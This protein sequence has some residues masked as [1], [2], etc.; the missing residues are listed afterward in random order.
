MMSGLAPE[1]S[2]FVRVVERGSFAAVA[3]EKGY[4]AS[5]V[6]RM[7]S[8]LEHSLGTKLLF[9][10]TRQLSLTPE[11][12][13]FLPHAQRVLE[14]IELAGAEISYS[15]GSPQGKIRINCGTAFANH[16]LAPML[17]E[18]TKRYPNIFLDIAV[19]DQRVDPVFSQADV[20]IRVGDLADSGLISIPLGK[21]A[22][23]I[24]ASPNYIAKHGTPCE[25]SDL[26]DHNCL[27]LSGF[28]GQSS[29]P[30]VKNGRHIKVSVS[31]TI[32]SDSAETL[33]R[34]AVAGVGI[35]RLGDF[36]GAE[37]LASG[38]LCSVLTDT[39]IRSEQPITAL[40]QPGRQSLP[41][42]RA[43]LDFLRLR[44]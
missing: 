22:R 38:Q 17:P 1:I 18:F 24:A 4:T 35:I 16:R 32:T 25:A 19:T 10:S 39:H 7:I 23:V 26:S 33:L 29:W 30:F 5:G 15:T 41:R 11:G 20:T 8:R 2:T 9:R 6:S 31:G 13:A 21:V 14:I 3:N 44:D 27:L 37:A 12:E 34:A 42:V 40:V 43:L 36:L 28:P